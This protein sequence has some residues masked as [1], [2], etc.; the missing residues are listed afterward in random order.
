MGVNFD[1]GPLEGL[2]VAKIATGRVPTVGELEQA[3]RDATCEHIATVTEAYE[4]RRMFQTP[5]ETE[6]I[7]VTT[8]V[9]CH[10]HVPTP[11]GA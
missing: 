9:T 1:D 6:F 11:E 10:A 2:G 5:A 7:T 4:R 8:C 3:L